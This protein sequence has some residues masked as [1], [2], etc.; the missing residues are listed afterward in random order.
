VENLH[1]ILHLRHCLEEKTW[2][3]AHA[4]Q[5]WAWQVEA[6]CEAEH[7]HENTT[8]S[9]WKCPSKE[10]NCLVKN[11]HQEEESFSRLA[12]YKH[13]DP[14]PRINYPHF[15]WPAWRIVFQVGINQNL[16]KANQLI[17]D[18]RCD[19]YETCEESKGKELRQPVK[20][21][22]SCPGVVFIYI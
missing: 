9:S 12:S 15:A 14:Q 21:K 19:S 1:V 11:A 18:P 13:H 10:Q 7:A 2:N 17:R 16:C 4:G 6:L 8:L 22:N 20:R 5:Y 3:R